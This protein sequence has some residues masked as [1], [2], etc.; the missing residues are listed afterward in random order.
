MARLKERRLEIIRLIKD[1]A[2][3]HGKERFNLLISR[4]GTEIIVVQNHEIG[5][6][7]P[8]QGAETFSLSTYSAAQTVP[9]LRAS[10]RSTLSLPRRLC[11]RFPDSP[12]YRGSEKLADLKNFA[13]VDLDYSFHPASIRLFIGATQARYFSP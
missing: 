9:V 6:F 5:I 7:A 8:L 10:T 11:L 1:L 13:V 12:S 4:S 3:D 2:A